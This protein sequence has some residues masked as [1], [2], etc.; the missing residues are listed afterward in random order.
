[1]LHIRTSG[2]INAESKMQ[3]AEIGFRF[4]LSV[5]R[6]VLSHPD[7]D[8]RYRNFTDSVPRAQSLLKSLPNGSRGLSPP[9]GSF[10]LPR[11]L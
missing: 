10:T 11:V 5:F 7:F 3:N 6:Y 1:M 4:Q 2:Q 9:V 8:R